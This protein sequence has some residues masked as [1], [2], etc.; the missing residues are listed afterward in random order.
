MLFFSSSSAAASDMEWQSPKCTDSSF[1]EKDYKL[2]N[3]AC[4]PHIF[5][6]NLEHES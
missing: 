4:V 2:K 5:M 6:L 3:R 1:M